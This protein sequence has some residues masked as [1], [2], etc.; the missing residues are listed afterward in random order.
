MI[1]SPIFLKFLELRRAVIN[2]SLY[3]NYKNW[4][5]CHCK[6]INGLC[7]ECQEK[8]F[9]KKINKKHYIINKFLQLYLIASKYNIQHKFNKRFNVEIK[10]NK[11]FIFEQDIITNKKCLISNINKYK[12]EKHYKKLYDKLIN[13]IN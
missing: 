11:I 3:C 2:Y 6:Y 4:I 9:N 10:N 7:I 5:Q 13:N 1:V 12:I 8:I